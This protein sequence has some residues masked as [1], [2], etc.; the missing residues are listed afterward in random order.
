MSEGEVKQ[1]VRQ[2]YDQVG[3]Q[4]VAG[5]QYQ[6]ARYEDLRP[7]SAE[8]I[9]RC[10]LRVGRHLA[11]AG[12]FLLDA[13]SGPVQYPEYLT[14]SQGYRLPGV[15]GYFDR[16]AAGSPPPPGSARPVR[17]GGCGQPALR[18]GRFRRGG[19]AAHPAPPAA[20]GTGQGLRRNLP[21]AGCR[22][23]RGGGQRLDGFAADAPDGLAGAPG[24]AAGRWESRACA[25]AR[26]RRRKPTRP[27]R[28]KTPPAHSS[29]NWTRPGC[30]GCWTAKCRSKSIP[31]AA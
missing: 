5:D 15:R 3:W 9:H 25:A 6:N 12:R 18:A 8:Y 19:F 20:G 24:R 31:G 11:P 1:Q 29:T 13:G 10:H 7:V 4:K 2:F 22:T 21:R 30:A 23:Q 14:Y 17:G 28:P 26:R 27:A 16:G